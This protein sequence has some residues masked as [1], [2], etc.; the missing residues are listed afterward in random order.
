MK[1][2]LLNISAQLS[3]LSGQA[4]GR[5]IVTYQTGPDESVLIGTEQ[6]ILKLAQALID[7]VINAKP[8]RPEIYGGHM[9]FESDVVYGKLD[10]CG[11]TA[12]DWVLVTA[13][14]EETKKVIQAVYS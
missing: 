9:L 6:Q 10:P 3:D 14:P 8:A 13:S 2:Q 11:T 7:S 4:V 5:P 12:L 1:Q